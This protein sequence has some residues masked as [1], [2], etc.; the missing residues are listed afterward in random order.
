MFIEVE[1]SGCIATSALKVFLK[2]LQQFVKIYQHYVH[3]SF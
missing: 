2:K 3:K 1:V